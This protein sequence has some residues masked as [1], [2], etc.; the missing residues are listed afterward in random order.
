MSEMAGLRPRHFL[1]QIDGKVARI[2][3][4]RPQRKNPLTFDSYA[5]L[6]EGT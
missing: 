3:L 2:R 1:W 5:P 6:F 4:D